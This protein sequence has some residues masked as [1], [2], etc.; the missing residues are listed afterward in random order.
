MGKIL[1]GT[2]GYSYTD[3]SG[4]FYPVD[5][6]SKE[7]LS[8]YANLFPFVELNYSYYQMPEKSQLEGMMNRVPGN[9][10]F[11]I[12]GH[13]SFTHRREGDWRTE[14]LNFLRAVDVLLQTERLAAVLLQFPYSFHYSRENR[15]Y[16]GQLCALMKE[17]PL[18][19]EFRKSE[20]LLP[21]VYEELEQRGIGYVITDLPNLENLPEK[22]VRTTSDTGYIRF[23]GRNSES[24]W[25][26]DSG[27]RY[28]YLYSHEELLSWVPDIETIAA[29][30]KR[31]FITFN[32]HLK[33]QA[34]RNAREL[35]LILKKQE[36]LDLI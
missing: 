31:L 28:N 32:N 29:S 15:I 34:I 25:S 20:W 27:T 17:L 11:A 10:L 36:N 21:S 5:L 23:H 9:F 18:V 22:D 4:I 13:R 19:I 14:A 24:W 2:S 8:F 16:L 1:I 26:G 3:W 33:G 30:V 6:P 35:R 7:F 12:K